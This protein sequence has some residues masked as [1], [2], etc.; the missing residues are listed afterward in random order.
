MAETKDDIEVAEKSG[1]NPKLLIIIIA[2][3]VLALIGVGAMFLMGD[4]NAEPEN[5]TTE[6][7]AKPKAAPIYSSVEAPFIVNFSKQSNGAV[8]YLQVKLK[9]MA[10]DQGVID[11]FSLNLPAIQHELLLLLYDQNFDELNTVGTKALQ[12][13]VLAK[14]NEI[15]KTQGTNGQLEAVYF[16]SFLMQ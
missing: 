12:E 11:S 2:V 5:E 10:R 15:L 4:N 13:K 14:I 1:G 3:L 6:T 16:T 8:R 7:V 9:V